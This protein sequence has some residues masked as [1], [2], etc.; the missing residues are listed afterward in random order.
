MDEKETFSIT[1][2]K[3]QLSKLIEGVIAGKKITISRA[4]RPIALLIKYEHRK[5]DRVPGGLKGKIKIHDD[6]DQIPDEIAEA[7]GIE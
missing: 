2:A 7:F 5:K 6:F 3:A 1:E 4:G